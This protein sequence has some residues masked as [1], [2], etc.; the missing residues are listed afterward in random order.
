MRHTSRRPIALTALASA[1]LLVTALAGT[2]TASFNAAVHSSQSLA[3]GRQHLR[4]IAIDGNSQ[5]GPWRT[6]GLDDRLDKHTW[7]QQ[8]AQLR[9]ELV[10]ANAGTVPARSLWLRVTPGADDKDQA[11]RRFHLA[12]ALHTP[13]MAPADTAGRLLTDWEHDDNA[14]R[15]PLPGRRLQPGESVTVILTVT[16]AAAPGLRNPDLPPTYTITATDT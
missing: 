9:H 11:A 12:I 4:I 8:T 16:G 5:G 1:A 13:G 6:V 14:T 7:P 10:I 15:L 3:T 2:T